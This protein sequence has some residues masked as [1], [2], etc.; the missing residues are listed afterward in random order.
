MIHK[1]R[2]FQ[3]PVKSVEEENMGVKKDLISII[4]PVYNAEKV[5]PRCLDSLLN[6]TYK[7]I[8][9]ILINDGSKDGSL[10]VCKKYESTAPNITVLSQENGGTAKARNAGLDITCGEYIMFVDADDYVDNCFCEVLHKA[11]IDCDALCIVSQRNT[12]GIEK[13]DT[14]KEINKKGRKISGKEALR[15]MYCGS[16]RRMSL[17]EVWGKLFN[18]SMWDELRFCEGMYYEDLEIMPRLYYDCETIVEIPY[19]G[20]NYIVYEESASHGKGTDDKRVRDSIS[21]R[22]KHIVFFEERNEKEL[23]RAIAGRLF[24]LIITSAQNGWVP[25]DQ[26][27]SVAGIYKKYW[28]Q[29]KH[30][31]GLSAKAWLRC[32]WFYLKG[33][34]AYKAYQG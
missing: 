5:L 29:F 17:V 24:E 3:G 14:K 7:Q 27:T 22:E 23:A 15:E 16:S 25:N 9:I 8:E 12:Y 32:E 6:Q 20:Y 11:I 1:G 10:A 34:R 21:I 26:I 19:T 2:E 28:K 33:E 18:H 13:S 30:N 31:A 4:V